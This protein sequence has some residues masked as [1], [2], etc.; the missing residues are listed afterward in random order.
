MRSFGLLLCLPLLTPLPAT[1]QDIWVTIVEPRDGDSVIGKI[2][3]VVEAVSRAEI[4]EIEFQIDGRPIG[5][6]AMEPFRMQ[7]DL[8]EKNVP[9][10]FSVVALDVE[11]NRATHSVNTQPVPALLSAVA[12]II[13]LR[14]IGWL[15]YIP[16]SSDYAFLQHAR[17]LSPA[18]Y[19]DG[20]WLQGL[21]DPFASAG[22][23]VGFGVIFLTM[24]VLRLGA[25]DL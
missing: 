8:G 6:L 21:V 1:G 25:R 17:W 20:M 19:Q 16:D 4:A 12:I 22:A 11:G 2:D 24:A 9:H 7:V 5:T 3:V 18:T 23:Y 14:V 10:R 13:A 15:R